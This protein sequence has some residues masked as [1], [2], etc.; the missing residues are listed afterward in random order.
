M[1]K[2]DIV[3]TLDNELEYGVTSVE[4][5]N[6]IEYAL[7]INIKNRNDLKICKVLKESNEIAVTEMNGED[8]VNVYPVFYDNA[9]TY[10][11]QFMK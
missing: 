2:K 3:I 11:E 8:L 9:R 7:M 10:L 4:I 5:I 6:G 1:L